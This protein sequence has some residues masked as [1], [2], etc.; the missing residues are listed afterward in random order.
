MIAY[1]KNKIIEMISFKDL[2]SKKEEFMTSVEGMTMGLE[3]L[4][5]LEQI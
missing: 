4:F 5:N 1:K 3:H 2:E